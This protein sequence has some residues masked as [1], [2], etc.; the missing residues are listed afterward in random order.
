MS[1]ESKLQELKQKRDEAIRTAEK[2]AYA[3]FCECAVGQERIRAGDIYDNLRTAQ[4]V[5]Y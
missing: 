5:G 3:Y 1:A 2:A 4:R